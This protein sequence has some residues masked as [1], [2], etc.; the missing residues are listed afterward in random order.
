MLCASLCTIHRHSEPLIVNR[1]PALALVGISS[2]CSLEVRRAEEESL[3]AGTQ[4]L[5]PGA[6]HGS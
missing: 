6:Q 2:F 3:A 4:P 5:T 1:L